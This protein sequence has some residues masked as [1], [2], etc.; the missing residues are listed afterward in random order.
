MKGY[1]RAAATCGASAAALL[2]N[3]AA[4]A[5]EAKREG[6]GRLKDGTAVEAITSTNGRGVSARILTCGATAP[7]T[8]KFS[9]ARVDPGR[10]HR[11]VMIHRLSTTR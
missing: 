8:P 3:G 2:L 9:S 7:Y 6:A 5:A 10:L 4:L 1:E 11:H